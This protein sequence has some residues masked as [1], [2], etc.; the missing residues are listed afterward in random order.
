MRG[1]GYMA[2]NGSVRGFNRSWIDLSTKQFTKKYV[3]R[4]G[5]REGIRGIRREYTELYWGC[6][7]KWE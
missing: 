7:Y 2:L 5:L 1:G 4:I 6:S 3:A